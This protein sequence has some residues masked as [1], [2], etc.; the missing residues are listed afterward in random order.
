MK[1]EDNTEQLILKAAEEE[2][3]ERGFVLAK[4]TEIAR[5]AGVTHAMLHYYYRTKENLFEQVFRQ[6]VQLVAELLDTAFDEHL[7]FAR[8]LETL[9]QVHFEFIRANPRLPFF[10][11]NE[12]YLDE[13]RRKICIPILLP[14]FRRVF[15]N[16]TKA[17]DTAVGR[18]EVRPVKASDLLMSIFS[19]NVMGFIAQPVMQAVMGLSKEEMD[20]LMVQRGEEIFE[21]IWSRLRIVKP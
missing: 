14:V 7:P 3:L 20:Q 15:A 12:I 21:T 1:K 9:I 8:Q 13:K 5:R 11:I 4:T 18:G 6:K 10:I 17:L 2:F 16:L 19:L